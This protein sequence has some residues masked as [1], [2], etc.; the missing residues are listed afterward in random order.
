MVD[1]VERSQSAEYVGPPQFLERRFVARAAGLIAVCFFQE[2]GE[3]GRDLHVAVVLGPLRALSVR[4]AAVAN[5]PTV[6]VVD[7]AVPAEVA[8]LVL[9]PI[10]G[11]RQDMRVGDRIQMQ[12]TDNGAEVFRLGDAVEHVVFL[13]AQ[14]AVLRVRELGLRARPVHVRVVDTVRTEWWQDGKVGLVLEQEAE[15]AQSLARSVTRRQVVPED[16]VQDE[17][18]ALLRIAM[19]D[20]RHFGMV[21]DEFDLRLCDKDIVRFARVPRC[22][23]G[24]VGVLFLLDFASFGHRLVSRRWW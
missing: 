24:G 11:D 9:V 1:K 2:L 22:E 12:E 17:R 18:V 10:E 3:V 5:V 15:V 21:I 23:G 7:S 14:T 8:A 16:A 20:R 19:R 4:S 13:D 6:S